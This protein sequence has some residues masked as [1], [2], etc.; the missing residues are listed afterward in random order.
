LTIDHASGARR[1]QEPPL[2]R[3]IIAF[4]AAATLAYTPLLKRLT[5]VK[6][7]TVAAII[8]LSPLAGALTA[9]AVRR[10]RPPRAHAAARLAA[11]EPL[12]L[13][14]PRPQGWA[15]MR[16]TAPP[17]AFAFLATAHRET[18]MDVNDT[19]GDRAAGVWTLPVV[20]GPRAAVVAAAGLLA[21]AA[22]VAAG[23]ALRG[24]GLAW[25]VRAGTPAAARPACASSASRLRRRARRGC[26]ARSGRA[27]LARRRGCAARPRPPWRASCA[28]RLLR[29]PPSGA[30]ASSRTRSRRRSTRRW[31]P[32]AWACC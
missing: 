29:S 24:G 8:A 12:N 25:A 16:A 20:A 15:G 31:Q 3:A 26:D 32:S 23:A 17:A 1:A 22:A 9:G 21:G 18:L 28:P 19:A 5:G 7:A 30:A 11:L 10:P 27:T 2:L 4:S 13:R 6:T 14:P